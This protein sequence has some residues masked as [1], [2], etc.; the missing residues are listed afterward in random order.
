MRIF[1]ILLKM[2]LL[3]M[4][5]VA[6]ELFRRNPLMGGILA[7]V[8]SGIFI[9]IVFA[10]R[11]FFRIAEIAGILSETVYQTF[12]MMFLFL[13]AGALPFVASTLL[14][15]SDYSLLFM[16][17]VRRIGVVAAKLLD[18]TVV[19]SLQFGA[20]GMP[21][22]VACAIALHFRFMGWVLL[23]LVIALFALLPALIIALALLIALKFAGARRLRR[24]IA[25]VNVVMA[26]FVC[27]TFVREAERLSNHSP[28]MNVSLVALPGAIRIQSEKSNYA[29]SAPFAR[30]MLTLSANS[31]TGDHDA[32]RA[33][34]TILA[35]VGG[36]FAACLIVGQTVITPTRVAAE[37]ETETV[38]PRVGA[39]LWLG[40]FLPPPILAMIAKDIKVCCR[41]SILLSQ[42]SMPLI[43]YCIPLLAGLRHDVGS[44]GELLSGFS[45]LMIGIILFMHSSILSLTALGLEGP[46]FWIVLSSPNKLKSALR[47]KFL[48]TTVGSASIA[49]TLALASIAVYHVSLKFALAEIGLFT[50]LACGLCGAGIGVSAVFPRFIYDN[51]AHR[52]SAWALVIGFLAS[53]GYL[54]AVAMISGATWIVTSSPWS[55]LP[56]DPGKAVLTAV[57]LLV[58]W[59]ASFV[60]LLLHLGARRLCLYEWEH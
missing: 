5:N 36:L 4:R 10:F 16:A 32:P 22:L 35:C 33:W 27:I 2:R 42:I 59:T 12:Y 54:L 40:W 60:W 1:R 24:A 43:L 23:P 47:A 46:A 8:G 38:A 13:L 11:I 19:S 29:P 18:A 25:L 41:D 15:S 30:V 58:A 48:E 51:P 28:L 9:A 14:L 31:V 49:S 44:P 20:L 45:G 50:L 55:F 34:L 52:V 39:D 37:G 17:P 53:T 57:A 3:M 7:M 6:R 26:T 56:I 21:A